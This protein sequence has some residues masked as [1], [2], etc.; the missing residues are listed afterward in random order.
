MLPLEHRAELQTAILGLRAQPFQS[1]AARPFRQSHELAELDNINGQ[2]DP[3]GGSSQPRPDPP[4]ETFMGRRNCFPLH[5]PLVAASVKIGLIWGGAFFKRLGLDRRAATPG[6]FFYPVR[7]VS[8][9]LN[10]RGRGDFPGDFRVPSAHPAQN[11]FALSGTAGANRAM[12]TPSQ[13][14]LFP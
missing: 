9:I 13:L 4:G 14:A 2:P 7:F 3:T 11:R 5:L 1:I 12:G 6:P 10:F 8:A